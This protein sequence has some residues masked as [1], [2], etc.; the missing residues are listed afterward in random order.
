MI[1]PSVQPGQT[2]GYHFQEAGVWSRPWPT[3]SSRRQGEQHGT[4]PETDALS[5]REATDGASQP[6]RAD[7]ARVP[8]ADGWACAGADGV[9]IPK[10]SCGLSKH[11]TSRWR[12]ISRTGR[13]SRDA[14]GTIPVRSCRHHD[15]MEIGYKILSGTDRLRPRARAPGV[16]MEASSHIGDYQSLAF[17]ESDP[18][19]D[20][21]TCALGRP[22]QRRSVSLHDYGKWL[23]DDG[24]FRAV[25]RLRTKHGDR[26]SWASILGR[27]GDR[28]HVALRV[29]GRYTEAVACADLRV[30][31]GSRLRCRWQR[32]AASRAG[33]VD[34]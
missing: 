31:C 25:A 24:L 1:V 27:L 20:E 12:W 22:G 21:V 19:G 32:A 9:T 10:K 30:I 33:T 28:I 34:L 11:A 2:A 6:V 13:G 17:S 4:E 8:S 29:F 18:A 16:M 7:R 3:D 26:G 15:V 23:P 14:H 5:I